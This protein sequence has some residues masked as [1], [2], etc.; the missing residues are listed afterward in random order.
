MYGSMAELDLILADTEQGRKLMTEKL[1]PYQPRSSRDL[2]V[3]FDWWSALFTGLLLFHTLESEESLSDTTNLVSSC[4]IYKMF[5]IDMEQAWKQNVFNLAST[6]TRT[7][8][9]E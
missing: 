4:L 2:H 5:W 1:E 3:V 7:A 9:E 8:Y 6:Q